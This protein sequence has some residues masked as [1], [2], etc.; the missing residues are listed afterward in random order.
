M[1]STSRRHKIQ[2]FNNFYLQVAKEDDISRLW[3]LVLVI[4]RAGMIAARNDIA[5][6]VNG[7]DRY[8]IVQLNSGG[9][10]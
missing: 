6:F 5:Y 2:N 3:R 10:V 9:G 7:H 1:K 4:Y 8:L